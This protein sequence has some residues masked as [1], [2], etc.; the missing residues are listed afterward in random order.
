MKPNIRKG[1]TPY[2]GGC[3]FAV[4]APNADDVF[5]VGTFN[6]WDKTKHR[7]SNNPDGVWSIDVPGVEPGDEYRYR[8][9]TAGK[10]YLRIDPYARRVTNSVGNTVITKPYRRV[11]TGGFTIPRLNEMVIYELHIGTFGKQE[12]QPDP[13]TIAGAIDR[14]PYLHDLG[15]NAVEVMPLA[16]F[17]GGYS[18]GYNP[19]NIFAVE[20]EYGTP[21]TFRDFVDEAHQ[22]GIAVIVDVVYN[23]FGPSDLSLWQFDGWS[24]NGKGGIYF[25]NDGRAQTPWGETR[26][27]YGRKEV[28][29]YIRDNALMWIREFDVDGLRW[30]MTAFIRNVHGRNNDPESDLP[31]GWSLMP[32]VN[33][34][35]RKVKREAFTIA[36]DL[37]G[38]AFMTK[39]QKDGGAGFDTQWAA[40]FVHPIRTA[41]IGAEDT[42]RDMDAVHNALLHRYYLDAFERVVYTESHDEVANGKARVPEEVD[43]GRASSWAAKKKS[44][45]GA[46]IVF[47]VQGIPMV[48]QGQEFLE[49]D[50]FHDQDPI[51]WKKKDRF[52]GILALYKDLIALR[53]NRTGFSKGLS[54]Q[55]VD[56][57]HVNQQ[58]KLVAFHRW[59]EGG[60]GDSV[61]VIA[62]FSTCS[63]EDY[64]LGLPAPGPWI[65][66]FNSDSR[67]YDKEFV[68]FGN[69]LVYAETNEKDGLPA[70]G[71]V[72]IGAYSALILS[73]EKTGE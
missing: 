2:K 23:H 28:R 33:K 49:D 73:Q 19:S 26:P 42:N 62:N 64:V 21:R 65:V 52:A 48:F 1:A 24:E 29:E 54:G 70:Q 41:L 59:A 22:L 10:E 17:A 32:W 61:V 53:L 25:Y 55:E 8:I 71:K 58:D 14:L 47:T 60:P 38:N 7:M 72:N 63:R 34:E 20:S 44:T 68:D 9:V 15:I 12:G 18:W 36:E 11:K 56:V 31:D 39:A 3:R 13:G 46:V 45:L 16:E 66:R 51:D 40:P 50:W 6:D 43:P 5:L 57:Y 35:I 30:D 67:Y 69:T 4:W 27:D 37:Q